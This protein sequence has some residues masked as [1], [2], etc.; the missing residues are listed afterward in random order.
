VL[1]KG[2]PMNAVK[3]PVHRPGGLL[4]VAAAVAAAASLTAGAA[5]ADAIQASHPAAPVHNPLTLVVQGGGAVA[6]GKTVQIKV[7]VPAGARKIN[8]RLQGHNVT[9]MLR[10]SGAVRTAVV[11]SRMLRPGRATVIVGGVAKNDKRLFNSDGFIVGRPTAT[12]FTGAASVTQGKG[13]AALHLNL[14]KRPTTL[15]IKLNGKLVRLL[16]SPLAG[17]TVVGLAADDG[18]RFGANRIQIAAVQASTGRWARSTTA[19]RMSPRTPLVSAGPDVRVTAG[20]KVKLNAAATRATTMQVPLG[21]RWQIVS[22]PKGADAH[23]QGDTTTHPQIKTTHL[24]RYRIR[25]ELIAR[26]RGAHSAATA[27][28]LAS[29][30]TT[31]DAAAAAPPYGLAVTTLVPNAD[32]SSR[33]T[34]QGVPINPDGTDDYVNTPAGAAQVIV[35]DRSTLAV[36]SETQVTD[37]T[38]SGLVAAIS[39]VTANQIAIITGA[40]GCCSPMASI[41]PVNTT[42]GFTTVFE[43]Q[44]WANPMASNAGNVTTGPN[45]AP[46]AVSGVLRKSITL[47]GAQVF[48]F[49]YPD[50]VSFDSYEPDLTT[51]G[52]FFMQLG[53]DRVRFMT[54]KSQ[55]Y[56][57]GVTV[58]V[59]N[60][61][62]QTPTIGYYY[63]GLNG[64][65]TNDQAQL[66]NLANVI[67]GTAT[68]DPGSVLELQTIGSPKPDTAEW[69]VV[70]N[71]LAQFGGTPSVWDELDG[72]GNYA[73]VGRN[74]P[75]GVSYALHQT[76]SA[77]AS[78]PLTKA[79]TDPSDTTAGTLRGVL[80]RGPDSLPIVS[81]S[82]TEPAQS[83]QAADGSTYLANPLGL[84]PVVEAAPQPWPL[85]GPGTTDAL[86]WI[87]QQL[88]LGNPNATGAGFCYQPTTWDLRAEY[89]NTNE[90][91]SWGSSNL[92]QLNALTCPTTN[93]AFTAAQC[94]AV[95][96]QLAQEFPDIGPAI[97]MFANLQVP[98]TNAQATTAIDFTNAASD[99]DSSLS[100][101]PPSPTYG[102]QSFLGDFTG[103]LQDLSEPEDAT[104]V[105]FAVGLFA[106]ALDMALASVTDDDGNPALDA[107]DSS[108]DQIGSDAAQ[109]LEKGS[110][111]MSL[112]EQMVLTDW[113]KLSTVAYNAKGIWSLNGWT[114]ASQTTVV[115]AATKAWLFQTM[116]PLAYSQIQVSPKAGNTIA[117]LNSYS[118][119]YGGYPA[120]YARWPFQPGATPSFSG[121]PTGG[122]ALPASAAFAPATGTN[123][124]GSIQTSY[125]WGLG[126]AVGSESLQTPT[127]SLTDQLFTSVAAGGVGLYPEQFYTWGWSN[128]NRY[129][130]SQFAGHSDLDN[131]FD[132]G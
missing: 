59:L 57:S 120:E 52:G 63:V 35:L 30:V 24:G 61:D 82:T 11:P 9:T 119:L 106:S 84:A 64:N 68:K 125:I 132:C 26:H 102:L 93:T 6:T 49:A 38:G 44:N 121:G 4:A 48:T 107:F 58:L 117:E 101:T 79:N 80:G 77:E 21:Y 110:Q 128:A 43:G 37:F 7:R 36:V 71:A 40:K 20:A 3:S 114:G 130:I 23:L 109:R 51:P 50:A 67:S 118:C 129:P 116:I 91:G 41:G 14:A 28:A 83:T 111:Q 75:T 16:R 42:D 89:C 98:F 1:T 25:L 97:A 13:T 94:G 53:P 12:L 73:L 87:S 55:G 76:S 27:P 62:L 126:N 78:A 123:A 17:P 5:M 85:T 70:G 115:K 72:T 90:A 19:F 104:G 105:T 39:K 54:P 81:A 65:A 122:R 60:P 18:L 15:R 74:V 31:I 127:S 103:P 47:A 96:A 88:G 8:V 2:N 33:T 34:I 32:G 100:V 113:T 66:T 86:Q 124:D 131:A 56:P 108:K 46:G 45:G 10:G 92:T 99:V 69:G 95:K 22:Q 112:I 29:D